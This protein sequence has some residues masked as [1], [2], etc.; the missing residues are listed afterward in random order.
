M[1]DRAGTDKV[2]T[3]TAKP[4]MQRARQ[5]TDMGTHKNKIR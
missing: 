4:D 1:H 5:G 3:M 2:M